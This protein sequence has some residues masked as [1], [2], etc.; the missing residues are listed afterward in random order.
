VE[1]DDP[2]PGERGQVYPITFTLTGGN[3]PADFVIPPAQLGIK[4]AAGDVSTTFGPATDLVLA[5]RLPPWVALR[6]A[7]IANTD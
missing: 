7:R 3:V 6:D 2:F 5:D 1:V 4:D